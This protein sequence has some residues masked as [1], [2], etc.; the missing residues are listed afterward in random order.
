MLQKVCSSLLRRMQRAILLNGTRIY[1]VGG[2]NINGEFLLTYSGEYTL[3]IILKQ[4][5]AFLLSNSTLI[6]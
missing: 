5:P 3:L 4:V 1:T 6:F 2:F